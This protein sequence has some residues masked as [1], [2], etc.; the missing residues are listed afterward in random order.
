[1]PRP[2]SNK[3]HGPCCGLTATTAAKMNCKQFCCKAKQNKVTNSYLLSSAGACWHECTSP[4]CIRV[5]QLPLQLDHLCLKL[6]VVL[7]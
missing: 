2:L 4:A 1:M 6:L 5:L 7:L 3:A